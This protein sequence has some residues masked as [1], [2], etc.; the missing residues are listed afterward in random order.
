MNHLSKQNRLLRKSLRSFIS[1]CLA[2]AFIVNTFLPTYS[3][4]KNNNSLPERIGYNDLSNIAYAFKTILNEDIPSNED[5]LYIANKISENKEAFTP[6]IIKQHI[7]EKVKGDL[8]LK[9]NLIE[10]VYEENFKKDLPKGTALTLTNTLLANNNSY[11]SIYNT[12]NKELIAQADIDTQAP[13]ATAESE[14]E[15]CNILNLKLLDFYMASPQIKAKFEDPFSSITWSSLSASQTRLSALDHSLQGNKLAWNLLGYPTSFGLTYNADGKFINVTTSSTAINN[16]IGIASD[17]AKI[18]NALVPGG[19]LPQ[20][21]FNSAGNEYYTVGAPPGGNENKPYLYGFDITDNFGVSK[22]A[23]D[24]FT[25]H[26]TGFSQGLDVTPNGLLL[27][28][29]E[30]GNLSAAWKTQ[31][32]PPV[33]IKNVSELREFTRNY[34]NYFEIDKSVSNVQD[35]VF[36][37]A[38]YVLP[39]T[40]KYTDILSY[41]NKPANNDSQNGLTVFAVNQN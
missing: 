39:D 19:F 2:L 10:K 1:L 33:A 40:Y 37:I 18:N 34:S 30:N 9:S 22:R 14:P 23:K 32:K 12:L 27:F 6:D 28:G 15:K 8:S 35:K 5:I 4:S 13:A 36:A 20:V 26:Y 21:K 31:S 41:L 7:E 3:I 25:S 16:L 11:K 24:T 38:G 17:T 29:I